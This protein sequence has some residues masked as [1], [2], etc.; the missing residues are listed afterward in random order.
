V[1]RPKTKK[2]F[3]MENSV[4]KIGGKVEKFCNTCQQSLTHLIKSITKLG[5]ISRVSC[6]KC[7]LS[8][9]F[10]ST[11]MLTKIEN[12]ATQ[13]GAPYDQ[14]RTYRTGQFMAH[15]T[16]GQGEVI[17]VFEARKIDVLFMDRVRRLIH[18]RY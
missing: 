15:P 18:S 17:S 4:Y 3:K 2:E 12:L 6:S 16:F 13:T 8:G 7:G 11:A 9:I 14:S 10:K 5:K 1:E